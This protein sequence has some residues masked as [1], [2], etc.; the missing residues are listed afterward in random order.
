M[1][2]VR[3]PSIWYLSPRFLA[4]SP[5]ERIAMVLFAVQ[6]FVSPTRRARLSFAPRGLFIFLE[7]ISISQLIPPCSLIMASRPPASREPMISSPIPPIPL[8]IS[9]TKPSKLYLPRSI[10]ITPHSAVPTAS[11]I[12][13]LTPKSA[14]AS[15]QRYGRSVHQLPSAVLSGAFV[16][17][18]TA[19]V[20]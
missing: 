1:L 13:T 15:T 7:I 9:V 8:H 6:M 19:V 2:A 20:P 12:R 10:P 4:S 16:A 18:A 14:A 17:S 11:T 5:M 3:L